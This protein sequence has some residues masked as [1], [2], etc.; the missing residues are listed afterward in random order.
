M[1]DPTPRHSAVRIR[2]GTNLGAISGL[3]VGSL[4]GPAVQPTPASLVLGALLGLIVG[5]AVGFGADVLD[6]ALTPRARQ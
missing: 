2:S 5:A 1:G 3:I 4:A 6:S